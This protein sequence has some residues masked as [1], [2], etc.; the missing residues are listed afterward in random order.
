MP[1]LPLLPLLFQALPA[2]FSAPG[3][4]G[5][6]FSPDGN[7]V[8]FSRLSGPQR[9]PTLMISYFREGRWSAPEAAPF[10]KYGEGDPAMAPDGSRLVFWSWRPAADK[11][12]DGRQHPDLWYVDIKDG[13]YSDPRRIEGTLRQGG[14]SVAADGTLYCFRVGADDKPRLVKAKRVGEGYGAF[15]DAG[16]ALNGGGGG[17][18]PYIVPDQSSIIFA[19]DRGGP[20]PKADLYISFRR[21][22]AWTPPKNLGPDVN[23][24][25]A[26]YCPCVS[27]DRKRLYFTRTK[28]GVLTVELGE[29]LMPRAAS[30]R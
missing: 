13:Q 23:S 8:Y 27:P 5:T 10:S 22:G 12:K 16:E 30:P 29:D 1:L 17:F 9:Q 15:E 25:E 19:S 28:A 26:E 3:T 18:D 4:F 7:T 21:D 20:E 2:P 6:A 14:P 24:S 11:P